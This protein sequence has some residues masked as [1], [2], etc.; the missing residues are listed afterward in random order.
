MDEEIIIDYLIDIKNKEIKTYNPIGYDNFKKKLKDIF[1]NNEFKKYTYRETNP[2]EIMQSEDAKR[3]LLKNELT[4][5][6]YILICF[7]DDDNTFATLKTN[8]ADL[9]DNKSIRTIIKR[10]VKLL[11]ALSVGKNVNDIIHLFPEDNK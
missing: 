5:K 9:D 10:Y 8:K 7:H 2:Y 6:N 4:A 1:G 11:L 3:T